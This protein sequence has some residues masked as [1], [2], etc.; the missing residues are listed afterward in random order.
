[1]SEWVSNCWTPTQQF[2]VISWREQVKISMRL[3]WGL[4]YTRPTRLVGF[5]LVIAHWNNSLRIDMSP[6]SDTLSRFRANQSLLFL[7]N[8]ARLAEKQQIQMYSLWFDPQSTALKA[9]TLLITPQMQLSSFWWLT[10]FFLPLIY[11]T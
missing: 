6:H 11:L 4:L 2:S 7:L 8:A 9:S 5:L 10:L 1:M 3:W